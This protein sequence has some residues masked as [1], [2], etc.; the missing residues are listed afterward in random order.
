MDPKN[1][2]KTPSQEV[3][4]RLELSIKRLRFVDSFKQNTFWGPMVYIYHK[5]STIHVGKYTSPMDPF[6]GPMVVVFFKNPPRDTSH[7]VVPI[8]TLV[9]SQRLAWCKTHFNEGSHGNGMGVNPQIRVFTPQIIH[10]NRVFHYKPSI[11]IGSSIIN[12]P[13]WEFSHYFW[14]HPYHGMNG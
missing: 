1:I 3:F 7:D 4:G 6:G 8:A 10:F 12:H 14:K 9:A 11:L 5:K 2:P 13:F